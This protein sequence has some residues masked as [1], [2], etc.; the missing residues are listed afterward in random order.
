MKTILTWKAEKRKVSDLIEAE[1]NPRKMSAEEEKNLDESIGEFGAVIPVVVNIGKR[2]DVLIGGHQRKKLYQKRGITEIDVMV[3]QRELTRDE[4]KKLNLRLNKNTG[5]W[6]LEK[7]REFGLGMLSEVGFN[8][9]EVT[10]IF[11]T[12]QTADDNFD[13][14]EAEKKAGTTKIKRGD[15]YQLGKHRIMC[16]DVRDEKDMKKL[17]GGGF[18]AYGLY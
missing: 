10:G 6:D 2:K 11:D 18:S 8:N 3:P 16:G 15:I 12:K 7:L 4:E 13:L 5:S 14:E 9:I 1:Y 17:M